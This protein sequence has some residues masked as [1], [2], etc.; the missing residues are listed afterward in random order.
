MPAV[1]WREARALGALIL[2]L[3]VAPRP[4]RPQEAGPA[5]VPEPV[6]LRSGAVREWTEFPETAHGAQLEVK[7][8]AANNDRELALQLR[9]QDVK[10]TWRVSINDKVLGTLPIDENDMTLYFPVPAGTLVP[11][12]NV[13]RIA[14]ASKSAAS[15]DI[16]AGPVRLI[17]RPVAAP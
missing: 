7:F 14:P 1:V 3:A 11:G 4:G 8:A 9:Q 13:L 17:Q 5:I 10:Q 6:H 12:E 16:R 2:L 15:D